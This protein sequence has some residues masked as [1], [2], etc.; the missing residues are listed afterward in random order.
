MAIHKK[1]EANRR[2]RGKV[3]KSVLIIGAGP[4]GL[5]AASRILRDVKNEYQPVI[6]EST[7]HVGGIACTIDYKGNRM[8]MGGHRF[9]SKNAEVLDEWFSLEPNHF[10]KRARVSRIYFQHKFF[11]YPVT[12]ALK[13]VVNLGFSRTLAA[14]FS[15]LKAV[16]KKRP[17]NS[18]ED[19]YIN[20]F[21]VALYR[22]F[23]ERYTEKL[24]GVHPRD[25]SADWGAQR[26]K[27]LSLTRVI[28]DFF[29]RPFK[30]DGRQKG[31]T[32]L[33]DWFWYPL[34]GPGQYWEQV[35]D[36]VTDAGGELLLNSDVIGLETCVQDGG[37]QITEATIRDAISNQ[38]R[39]I[40]VD[41]VISSM[42]V[43]DL[44]AALGA[45]VP[46]PIRQIAANLPYRD[47]MMVGLLVNK[48]ALSARHGDRISDCWIYIQDPE[49]K[50]GRIQIYNNWSAEMVADP[51]NTVWLGLEYCCAQGDELWNARDDE[52]IAFA[53][54]E[55]VNIGVIEKADVIDGTVV[56]VK[57]AYPA[58]FGA[59]ER[60]GEVRNY[61]DSIENL[62]CVGRNGQHRYN[63][64]D[65]SMLTAF[66]AVRALLGSDHDKGALW[67]VNTE[68]T[69]H[70]EFL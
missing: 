21:G 2:L 56:R 59:Y 45:A 13:T 33:I 44:V 17:E 12:L 54:E 16:I 5:A 7:D 20:R 23:F 53:A 67:S 15:Y 22:L 9:F 38:V 1:Q 61:L 24:W 69:Y 27:G 40:S 11:D 46:E 48:L 41:A 35:A 18:L 58:Y 19:F 39:Q 62:Y 55:L 49:V 6:I 34:L 57:K 60:F 36:S 10:E 50:L 68:Q 14:G 25:L 66:E 3:L 63:N 4:A 52:F 51:D 65:H 30:K 43:K 37:L 26:V 8:D 32:S 28:L 64:M 31:E 42:P 47:F 29:A 70:E